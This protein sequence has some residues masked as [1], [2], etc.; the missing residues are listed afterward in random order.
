M[1][2]LS[3]KLGRR[4]AVVVVVVVVVVCCL[5]LLLLLL[6]IFCVVLG[7]THPCRRAVLTCF[8]AVERCRRSICSLEEVTPSK[9]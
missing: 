8:L 5:L 7:K 4:L 1:S 2:E 6:S 9:S 3:G